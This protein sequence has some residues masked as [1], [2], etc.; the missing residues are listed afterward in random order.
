[1]AE[2]HNPWQRLPDL[3]MLATHHCWSFDRKGFKGRGWNTLLWDHVNNK[4]LFRLQSIFN[5]GSR[6]KTCSSKEQ[7]YI[8][9]FFVRTCLGRYKKASTRGSECIV[10]NKPSIYNT[11]K[12]KHKKKIQKFHLT[13][14]AEVL[15]QDDF[16]CF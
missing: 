6:T 2:S 10:N 5:T 14:S 15:A 8:N 1:M 11:H 12:L 9:P 7:K 3:V 13:N 4:S 16:Y